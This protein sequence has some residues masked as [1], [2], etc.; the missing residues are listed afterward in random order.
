[1]LLKYILLWFNSFGNI[2][3]YIFFFFFIWESKLKLYYHWRL[4]NKI[5]GEKVEIR[6]ALVEFGWVT[7]FA[8]EV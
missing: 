6:I 2:Y 7:I 1:M 8:I 5:K 3:I 4:K